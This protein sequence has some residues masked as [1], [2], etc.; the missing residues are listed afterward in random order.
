MK[1]EDSDG[2]LLLP[3]AYWSGPELQLHE[4]V[5]KHEGYILHQMHFQG[6]PLSFKELRE[7]GEV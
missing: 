1:Y 7:A 5:E 3:Q 4:V 6:I 2:R